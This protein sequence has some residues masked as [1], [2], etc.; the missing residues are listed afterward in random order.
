MSK[1]TKQAVRPRY[2]PCGCKTILFPRGGVVYIAC[3]EGW[4]SV[5]ED[6]RYAFSIAETEKGKRVATVA[7]LKWFS[8]NRKDGVDR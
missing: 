6:M 7:I 1:S 3:K 8:E 2:C 4:K 5:P